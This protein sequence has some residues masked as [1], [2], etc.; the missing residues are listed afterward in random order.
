MTIQLTSQGA[1]RIAKAAGL[2][3]TDAAALL[4]LCDTEADAEALA[5][6]FAPSR[7]IEQMT[8]AVVKNRGY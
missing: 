5:Q 8:D 4:Q 2:Q 1:A 7:S 3:M 6:Q